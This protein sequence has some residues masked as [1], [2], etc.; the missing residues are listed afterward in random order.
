MVE[1]ESYGSDSEMT[2]EQSMYGT[3]SSYATGTQPSKQPSKHVRH[4]DQSELAMKAEAKAKA[5]LAARE[6]NRQRRDA[7][8]ESLESMSLYSDMSENKQPTPNVKTRAVQAS[9]LKPTAASLRK[10]ATTQHIKKV[11]TTLVI[12]STHNKKHL[13]PLSDSLDTPLSN[14][15][16]LCTRSV[17]LLRRRSLLYHNGP[18]RHPSELS[19]LIL[20]FFVNRKSYTPYIFCINLYFDL[21]SGK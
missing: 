1:E 11:P 12:R 17:R 21:C 14:R 10:N 6:R 4:D 5:I 20:P 8:S 18:S 7:C 16:L 15:T 3:E 13:S 9:Y 19:R 2:D